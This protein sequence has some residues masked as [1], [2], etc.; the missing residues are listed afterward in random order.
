M[1]ILHRYIIKELLP[2]FFVGLG[3]FTF[4]FILNP[5]LRLVDLI[6][7]KNVEFF[8]VLKLFFYLL[9]STVAIVIP[10]ATL[11]AVLMAFGRFSS[12]S[13]I[14]AMRACGISYLDIFLPVIIFGFII[15]IAGSIFNDTIL[16][17]G[18][19]AF[20]Q[21]YKEIIQR[22][23]LAEVEEHTLT[24]IGNR[25]VGIDRIDK[26]D[27]IMYGIVIFEREPGGRMRTITAKRG[28]WIESTEKKISEN[29][30]LHIMR[31]Q[32]EDGNI[33]HPSGKEFNQFS[34]IPFKRMII[35]F[36]ETIRYLTEV[37]KG[38]REKTTKEILAEI[39]KVQNTG[40]RP[41]RLWVEYHKRFSIP[42][43]ALAF[44]LLGA[45]LGIVSRRSGKSVALG[46][47]VI[48]IILYYL[49]YTFGESIAREG[50]LNEFFAMWL[51][52]FIFSL[53]GTIY[54]FKMSKQ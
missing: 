15:S 28:E 5:I 34:H 52:N 23:P 47:S 26:R 2:P 24:R 18:N 16:P 51:P 1:K 29:K 54:I 43:A 4:V 44:V 48:I 35:N 25:I 45:P 8:T 31:L 27:D 7:V 10:M 17:A 53:I 22:K 37:E 14:I 42:F 9:P 36:T 49:V 12:D 19:Y 21:L 50:K 13:E 41:Y 46:V 39:R 30:V 38:T 32:L 33:Q 6:I 40:R 20:K 11:V 3:F